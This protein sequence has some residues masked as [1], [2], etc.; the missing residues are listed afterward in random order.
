MGGI[1]DIGLHS[2]PA[3]ALIMRAFWILSFAF[4]ASF[5]QANLSCLTWDKL[6]PTVGVFC[7]FVTDEIHFI[8]NVTAQ[9]VQALYQ[10][11]ILPAADAIKPGADEIEQSAKDL[12]EFDLKV[13]PVTAAFQFGKTAIQKNVS[14]AASEYVSGLHDALEVSIGFGKGTANQA[15]DLAT[16]G[17][18]YL[19][20]VHNWGNVASCMIIGGSNLARNSS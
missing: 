7:H 2:K 11:V 17:G 6:L 8:E 12:L 16:I 5:V 20:D 9:A 14:A 15:I 10:E 1:P 13:I 19:Y 3:L 18:I 4:C